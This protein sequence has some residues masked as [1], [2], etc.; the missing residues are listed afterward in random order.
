MNTIDNKLFINSHKFISSNFTRNRKL[1]FKEL[2]VCL[3]RFTRLGLQTEL[4]LFYRD[5]SGSPN[6][7]KSIS[8]STFSQARQ[9]LKPSV[10]IELN[11]ELINYF[12]DNTSYKKMWKGKRVIAIDGSIITYQPV[13]IF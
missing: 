1:G 3:L 10:F 11:K 5:I 4:D 12:E 2:I 9:K 8:K 13:T 7:F 6:N